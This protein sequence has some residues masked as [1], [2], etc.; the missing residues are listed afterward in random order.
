[1]AH[2]TY[3]LHLIKTSISN[4]FLLSNFRQNMIFAFDLFVFYTWDKLY[5]YRATVT[6]LNSVISDDNTINFTVCSEMVI[7]KN[8]FIFTNFFFFRFCVTISR[9]WVQN[10]ILTYNLRFVG[11][12]KGD[13]KNR[14]A[15]FTFDIVNNTAW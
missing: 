10:L 15:N 2:I 14:K 6:S 5:K 4:E 11:R 13:R 1:M 3:Y 7:I 12:G 9:N 8:I